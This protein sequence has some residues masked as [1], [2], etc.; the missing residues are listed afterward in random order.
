MFYRKYRTEILCYQCGLK[1]PEVLATY[2]PSMS[3]EKARL[4]RP[5]RR[6]PNAP[7]SSAVAT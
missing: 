7:D 2:R 4:P 3:W 6:Q 5:S 1:D